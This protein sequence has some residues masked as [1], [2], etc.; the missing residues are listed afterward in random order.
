M[1]KWAALRLC[2]L[3]RH[4]WPSD[5]GLLRTLPPRISLVRIRFE[6]APTHPVRSAWLRV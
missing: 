5:G 6:R 3:L 4:L 2:A 1:G